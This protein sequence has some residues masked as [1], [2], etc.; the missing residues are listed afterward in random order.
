[1]VWLGMYVALAVPK[2]LWHLSRRF[3]SLQ[4]NLAMKVLSYRRV[5]NKNQPD[6]SRLALKFILI[7]GMHHKMRP[8]VGFQLFVLLLAACVFVAAA[9]PS[10]SSD[11]AQDD[12]QTYGAET[13]GSHKHGE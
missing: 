3:S 10:D 7:S 9:N 8:A 1:M 13:Q 4:G 5:L 6:L 2:T 11:D 12:V